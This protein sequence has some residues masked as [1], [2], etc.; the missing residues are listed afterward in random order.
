V[1]VYL[2]EAEG[3]DFILKYGGNGTVVFFMVKVV[4]DVDSINSF[5]SNLR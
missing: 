5:F 3:V 4:V 2:C 1:E